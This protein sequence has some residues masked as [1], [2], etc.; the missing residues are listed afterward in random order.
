M[1]GLVLTSAQK[2]IEEH[3]YEYLVVH[4]DNRTITSPPGGYDP[5]RVLLTVDKD[6][7]TKAVIG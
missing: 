3:G 7:V 2:Y 5:L 6:V 1:V 4:A